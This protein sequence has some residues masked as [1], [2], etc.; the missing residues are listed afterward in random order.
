MSNETRQF[1]AICILYPEV[2]KKFCVEKMIDGVF[3]ILSSIHEVLLMIADKN[4]DDVEDIRRMI[5]EVNNENV[6]E[7]ERLSDSLYYYDVATD[8]LRIAE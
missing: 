2:L 5:K 8:T 3:V 6:S 7:V 4:K 1:G